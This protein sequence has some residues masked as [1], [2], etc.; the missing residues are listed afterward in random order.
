MVCEKC[1][2]VMVTP[3][4]I[5]PRCG[6]VLPQEKLH[7]DAIEEGSLDAWSESAIVE[8]VAGRSDIIV[9]PGLEKFTTEHPNSIIYMGALAVRII[10]YFLALVTWLFTKKTIWSGAGIVINL[11]VAAVA[12]LL[13]LSQPEEQDFYWFK[14][15]ST[16]L[17]LLDTALT[18][19]VCCWP[20][21]E[22]F[23]G[24]FV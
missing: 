7:R 8:E 10:F 9:I 22:K 18:M 1:G 19:L 6:Y 2:F 3:E 20:L 23:V 16:I 15:I 24:L 11:M 5:C 13:I 4:K 14:T 17:I 21:L 12:S